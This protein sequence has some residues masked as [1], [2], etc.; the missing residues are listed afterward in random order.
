VGFQYL[1][2]RRS[3]CREFQLST[4]E[5]YF[6]YGS[7]LSPQ[8]LRARVPE[9]QVIGRARLAGWRLLFDKHGRDGSAKA[10]IDPNPEH[11]V[12][13]AVYR[14]APA[15]RA[16]LDLV[17]G[18]GTDYHL[19]ELKVELG[20]DLV[21]VYT[22]VALRRRA[23]LPLQDWYL[24]HILDGAECHALPLA[25]RDYLQGFRVASR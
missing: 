9:A 8:R 24:T 20:A 16:P 19:R 17:E 2:A 3:A 1:S 15:H 13:G 25:W 23:G 4:L 10:N 6:A 11:E 18:L 14:L 7:N 22:Y 21:C 5:L 12:W